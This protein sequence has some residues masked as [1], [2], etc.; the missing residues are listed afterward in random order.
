MTLKKQKFAPGARVEIRDEEWVIRRV[1]LTNYQGYQ[2]TCEGISELVRGKEALFLTELEDDITVLDPKE[3]K[4]IQDMSPDFSQSLLFIESQL[5]QSTPNDNQIHVAKDAAMDVVPYQ[6]D[7]TYQALEQPRQRI[8]IADAVGLGKTLEAGILATELMQRGRGKR[9]L[10]LT[11]KSMM[12]QFQ[13]EFW[14]RFSIPL[15]RLDSNGLQRVRG[16]IPA[17]HNPFYY[18]DKSIISIDTLKQD[19]EFKMYLEKAYWD[20]IIID[21][22]HNVADRGTSSQRAELAQLLARKSDTLIMLSATPHDGRAKSFASLMNMLDPTAIADPE[23][24]VKGDFSSKGLVV[25]R[26]KHDIKNQVKTEFKERSVH[27]IRE[28]ASANEEAI[29]NTLLD[30]P[31]TVKGEH[32]SEKPG[33]LIRIGLQ[34]ALFSSPAACLK[35]V[36]QRIRTLSPKSGDI[37]ISDDVQS[38]INGLRTLQQQLHELQDDSWTKYQRLLSLVKSQSFN[39]NKNN[40]NDRLVIFSERIETLRYLEQRLIVDLKL[41]ENQITQLHGGMSDIEQQEVV[42]RFGKSE[43]KLR[44]LLCSDVASEGINLHYLSHRL[45]HFDLPWSLMVFQ[46]RNGRVDRYGQT[47]EPQIY[48]LITESQ[49]ETIRGDVRILE[50]LQQKDEQAYENIGDPATF[51][52]VYDSAKEEELAAEAMITGMS[53]QEF[54]K[55]YVV[56]AEEN[57]ADDLMAMFMNA[58]LAAPETNQIEEQETED[59]HITLFNNDYLYA[60]AALRFINKDKKRIAVE[61]NDVSQIIRLTAPDDL[62]QKFKAFPPE[63]YPENGDFILTA[64]KEAYMEE[65]KRARGDENAWPKHHYLWR[66]HPLTDWLQERMLG[67]TGRHEA[68]VLGISSEL[69]QDEAIFLVSA[70]IPNRKAHPVI[71]EWY[72]V[73]TAKGKVA[74]I[75][76]LQETLTAFADK[77]KKLPN[78]GLPVNTEQLEALR[79]PVI[80]AVENTVLQKKQAF[81]AEMQPKLKQQV[82]ELAKLKSKQVQQME[83]DLGKGLE[84]TRESKRIK[85]QRHIDKVFTE[86]QQWVEDTWQTEPAPYLQ[87]IAVIAP[88]NSQ[89]VA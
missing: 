57:E 44:V 8:L 86:Y 50:I 56:D 82:A 29:Y 3:T 39:W 20:I 36:E 7:P 61:F 40:T 22:A 23:N 42:E 1:D 11:L 72:A 48:Y 55:K 14:T 33:Q 4:L 84:T 21:E 41:K 54:D 10:V 68:L 64:D 66:K 59:S 63:I 89:D 24:Y 77:L 51:M 2:L 5:R 45:I 32:D 12:T 16:R 71:W 53:A 80:D 38:E 18:Y 79:A 83:L 47:E 26:F 30:I 25:R 65:V 81:D 78:T 62:K 87:L 19:N 76:P 43:E 75:K 49:N 28:S 52:D 17:N 15:T 88:V 6:L 37:E 73:H 69:Q 67:N 74:Y 70:L 35:S 46:Q 9:I 58:T 31:F 85:K 34:K 27:A 13:K 60:K